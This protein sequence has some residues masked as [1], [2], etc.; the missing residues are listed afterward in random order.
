MPELPE[1][2]TVRALLAKTVIGKT[3][4]G[5]D[6]YRE[7]NI[8]TPVD[9]FL[10]VLLNRT[11]TRAIRKGKVLGFVFDEA[12]VMTS[13]LRMEGKFFYYQ[14]ETER[15]KHD[16]LRFRF[17][18]GTSLVYNDVRKF[19]HLALYP[20]D[21]YQRESSF[22]KLGD[23]PFDADATALFHVLQKRQSTIKESLMDQS[24]LAGIGN[25]YCDETLFACRIHPLTPAKEITEEQCTSI[26]KESSRI[27][28]E[29]I[30]EGGSTVRSYHPGH[31][32]DGLMQSKLLVY[33]SP[34]KPCPRCGFPLNKI[35]VGGRG[36]TYCPICQKD[37]HRP[38]VVGVTGMIHAGKSSVSQYLKDKMGYA[39]F[40][41][42]LVA[43]EAYFDKGVKSKIKKLFGKQSYV[44]NV[45]NIPYIRE[46]SSVKP[47]LISSLNQIIHP[48]VYLK[49]EEFIRKHRPDECVVL[50]V[51]LLFQS[52][53]NE[54]CDAT[55]L[56]MSSEESRKQRLL[57]EG[58]DA[59][60]LLQINKSY[61]IETIKKKARFLLV[62]D[63]DLDTLYQ[64][65][66][67]LNLPCG[68]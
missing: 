33:D 2:E 26:L 12:Y 60:K 42:D 44:D 28:N 50:D 34:G 20:M 24:I 54:L 11:V 57:D 58:R 41:A 13:H 36:S 62:N 35:F 29:A 25:I 53:M 68:S 65:I 16:I 15:S 66:E 49:A 4:A 38:F 46:K 22:A 19:G 67:N 17:T 40:D 55:I 32:I 14:N 10:S 6:L 48:Y 47:E 18:D 63:K 64:K 61:P 5:I 51:P 27:L 9:E 59:K 56:V 30:V 45:P 1:V 43:K 39:L 31:G 37:P 8:D 52:K 21:S 23:E 7:K 3:V